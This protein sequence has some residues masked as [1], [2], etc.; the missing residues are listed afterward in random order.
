MKHYKEKSFF[1]FKTDSRKMYM[2]EAKNHHTSA[3]S[4]QH[5]LLTC[6]AV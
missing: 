5:L 3:K 2:H 6:A 1:K 4:Q